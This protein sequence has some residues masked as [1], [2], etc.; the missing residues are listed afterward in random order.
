MSIFLDFL[1]DFI[2]R[3]MIMPTGKIKI[4]KYKYKPQTF[5]K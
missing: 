3:K 5:N 1:V 4:V 2:I